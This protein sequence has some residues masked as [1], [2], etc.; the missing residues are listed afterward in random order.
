MDDFDV[1]GVQKWTKLSH[2][3]PVQLLFQIL[4]LSSA[5]WRIGSHRNINLLSLLAISKSV[6]RQHSTLYL[7]TSGVL[8]TKLQYGTEL[9]SLGDLFLAYVAMAGC[10]SLSLN[11]GMILRVIPPLK[12]NIRD[13]SSCCPTGFVGPDQ[14]RLNRTRDRV[15]PHSVVVHWRIQ[16]FSEEG[17]PNGKQEYEIKGLTKRDGRAPARLKTSW[18]SGGRCKPPSGVWGSAPENFETRRFFSHKMAIF[19]FFFQWT[20]VLPRWN[21]TIKITT[22]VWA[23]VPSFW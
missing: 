6:F 23:Q 4:G 22:F 17:A 2:G 20:R 18:G 15:A 16:D 13:D 8:T 11:V 14:V 12:S 5:W 19:D 9:F 21:F 7:C 1:V 3:A 10:A